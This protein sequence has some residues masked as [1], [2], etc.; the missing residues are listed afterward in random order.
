M[1]WQLETEATWDGV[2][3]SGGGVGSRAVPSES[4]VLP[5]KF[6]AV[7]V[8]AG[9]RASPHHGSQA[10]GCFPISV[11]GKVTGTHLGL[12]DRGPC[13][14]LV[15][16]KGGRMENPHGQWGQ[17][18][19]VSRAGSSDSRDDTPSL[20]PPP[21]K[22]TGAIRVGWVL[23]CDSL[24]FPTAVLSSVPLVFQASFPSQPNISARNS[25]PF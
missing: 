12:A 6:L 15:H 3:V 9:G 23:R 18:A 14:G 19:P 4:P 17:Q 11:C 7:G 20:V 10:K 1:W 8:S 5:G 2:S 16:K 24:G 13:L 22:A 25:S 21:T